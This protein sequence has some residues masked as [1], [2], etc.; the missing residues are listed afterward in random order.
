[1]KTVKTGEGDNLPKK[2]IKPEELE[3]ANLVLKA[4]CP[5]ITKPFEVEELD[6]QGSYEL[7]HDS[8]THSILYQDGKYTIQIIVCNPGCHTMP[9]GDPGYPDEWDVADVETLDYFHQAIERMFQVMY[10]ERVNLAC[11]DV[12][13]YL[14]Q[15]SLDNFSW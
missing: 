2:G 4:L 5:E 7:R 11:S 15:K 8:L 10:S 12:A 9:N 1:M 6:E 13:E 3:F 14:Y